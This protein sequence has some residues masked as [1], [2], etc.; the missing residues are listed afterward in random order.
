MNISLLPES[1]LSALPTYASLIAALATLRSKHHTIIP[2]SQLPSELDELA[3]SYY[4]HDSRKPEKFF[5][6]LDDKQ[7]ALAGEYILEKKRDLEGKLAG[8]AAKRRRVVEDMKEEVE[9]AAEVRIV[10]L[11]RT[12]ERREVLRGGIGKV[13]REGGLWL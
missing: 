10:K 8:V 13:L 4:P 1:E 2:P 12:E 9:K 6:K 11:R 7:H 5:N 3:R